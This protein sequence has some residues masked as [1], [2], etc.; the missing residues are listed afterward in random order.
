MIDK[1]HVDEIFLMKRWRGWYKIYDSIYCYDLLQDI[2]M[3]F[4]FLSFTG[5][6]VSFMLPVQKIYAI[7]W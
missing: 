2:I 6:V 4:Q 3:K 5:L 1:S 7:S